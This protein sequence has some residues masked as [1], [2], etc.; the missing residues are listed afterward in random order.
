MFE[1]KVADVIA[2][3]DQENSQ[4]YIIPLWDEI[5]HRVLPIWVGIESGETIAQILDET[6]LSRPMTFQFAANLLKATTAEVESVRI[7][8]LRA[9]TY[10]AIVSLHCGQNVQAIDARPSDAIALALQVNSPIYVAQEVME[11]Q[12]ILI[13]PD[14]EGSP[15]ERGLKRYR[16]QQEQHRREVGQEEQMRQAR[17]LGD[18]TAAE[19]VKS[20]RKLLS[21]LFDENWADNES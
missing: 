16:N 6:L 17:I 20:N 21:F 8:E 12:G 4:S 13:P 19:R 7:A 3:T 11:Q 10:Y 5:N 1:V 15:L 2:N 14:I 9:T 18:T